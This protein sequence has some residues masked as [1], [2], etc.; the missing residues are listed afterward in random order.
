MNKGE[1]IK[2][3]KA[4]HVLDVVMSDDSI[5]HKGKAIR[6]R[7][8]ELPTE[9]II[10]LKAEINDLE[11]KLAINKGAMR[12]YREAFENAHDEAVKDFCH[13]L[14][15]KAED[16]KVNIDEL[17]DFIVEWGSSSRKTAEIMKETNEAIAETAESL[18]HA[19]ELCDGSVVGKGFYKSRFER[20]E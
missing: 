6:K 2:L 16:G 5:R 14:I 8:S 7:L 20:V 11:T 4:M 19:P 3:G 15:D 17:P 12:A 9:D 10:A 1:Y 13:F 18:K